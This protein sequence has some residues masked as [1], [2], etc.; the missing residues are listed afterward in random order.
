MEKNIISSSQIIL[1][2]PREL[3][4]EKQ[5][6]EKETGEVED[7]GGMVYSGTIL[8]EEGR[9]T[10]PAAFRPENEGFASSDITNEGKLW[11]I[12]SLCEV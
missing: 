9:G 6:A 7:E 11:K 10:I 2:D 4:E 8:E 1:S 5:R 3:C 12:A